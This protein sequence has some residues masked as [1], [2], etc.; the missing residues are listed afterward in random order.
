MIKKPII[1]NN[2]IVIKSIMSLCLVFD[3]RVIDG[4]PAANFLKTLKEYLENPHL[5]S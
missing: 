5:L 2:E 1:E 4:A 3:H